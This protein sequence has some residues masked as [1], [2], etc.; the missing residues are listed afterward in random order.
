MAPYPWLRRKGSN[1]QPWFQRPS[2]RP[3]DSGMVGPAG[4]EPAFFRLRGGCNSIFASDPLWVGRLG[5]EPSSCGL[6]VRSITLMLTPRQIG[7]GARDQPGRSR[8]DP[9]TP[10]SKRFSQG[11]FPLAD[12]ERCSPVHSGRS[13]YA[14]F[15]GS[16]GAGGSMALLNCQRSNLD[17]SRLGSGG[18]GRTL[19]TRFKGELNCRVLRNGVDGRS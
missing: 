13:R 8:D 9:A 18:E 2:S 19:V 12:V 4:I 5:I 1:L 6:K 11:R 14:A 3:R 7:L 16:P 17:F 10:R 15:S